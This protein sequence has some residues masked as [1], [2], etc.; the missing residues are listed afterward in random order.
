MIDFTKI[1]VQNPDIPGIRNNPQLDWNQVTNEITGDIKEYTANYY[2]ITFT[3]IINQYLYITGSFHKHWNG[4]NGRKE[5]NYNDFTFSDLTAVII[6]FCKSFDLVPDLC[7]LENIEFGVNITP[8]VPTKEFLRSVINHK[9]KPFNQEYQ[10]NK[11]FRECERQRYSIKIYDKGLQYNQGNILRFE[12]KT[13]KMKHLKDTGVQTLAD[14]LNPVKIQRLGSI[15]K[16]NFNDLLVY[17]YTIP[18]TGINPRERLILTQG[19]TPAYWLK[20]KESNPNL[21]YKKLNRFKD[22]VKKH[23]TQDIQKITGELISQKWNELLT[24]DPKTLQEL[25][26]GA[27]SE[28]TEI[29]RYGMGLKP[30][31][32]DI[33]ETASGTQT[34]GSVNEPERRY[35]ST[36]KKE[37]THQHPNSK[38]C[39]AKYVGYSQAHRCRNNESNERYREKKLIKRER[40]SL[41]L[42]DSVPF[43]RTRYLNDNDIRAGL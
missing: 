35:C 29:N 14:L 13:V 7:I 16:A 33:E 42:F 27:I 39:S 1:K 3:I 37:I 20:L 25:T 21:Y 32:L 31:K 26:G 40:E 43:I 10:K 28:F 8:T 24:Y 19:Q 17:D 30:V 9:G 41:T 11:N 22:L 34:E 38:F 36:C 2:G 18:S 15:L 12:N 5:Q 6:E 4:I 23:G